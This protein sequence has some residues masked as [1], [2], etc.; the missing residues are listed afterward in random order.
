MCLEAAVQIGVPSVRY[1]LR[2][3]RLAGEGYAKWGWGVGLGLVRD[4][5]MLTCP[6]T[7]AMIRSRIV[8][9]GGRISHGI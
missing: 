5:M 2:S 3:V 7:V 4:D 8:D 9:G 1:R 6:V